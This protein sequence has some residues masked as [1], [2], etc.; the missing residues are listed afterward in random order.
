MIDNVSLTLCFLAILRF[1]KVHRPQ[2]AV[3]SPLL[4]LLSFKLIVGLL[5]LQSLV[6]NFI[7]IPSGLTHDG[8]LAPRDIKYGIPDFLVCVEMLFFSLFFHLA[9]RSREYHP[10]FE[11]GV[12]GVPPVLRK[13]MGAAALDALNPSDLIAAVVRAFA[14]LAKGRAERRGRGA[15]RKAGGRHQRLES[16]D[17]LVEGQYGMTDRGREDGTAYIGAGASV[18]Y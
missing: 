7:S 12:A 4:K 3:H 1:Y 8:T 5:F 13:G 15:G 9:F 10:E 17:R 6:F 16:R 18:R 2:M 11:S 14:L